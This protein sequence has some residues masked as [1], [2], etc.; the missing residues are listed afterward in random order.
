[1][2]KTFDPQ[3]FPARVGPPLFLA[4]ATLS[5]TGMSFVQQGIVVMSVFFAALYHLTLAQMGLVTTALSLGIMSSM[6]LMGTVVDRVGPRKVLFFGAVAMAWLAWAM[7]PVRGFWP[8]LVVLYALGAALAMAP[9]SGTKAVFTAFRNRPRGMVMGIR[10][11]GVPI[12]ALL[13]ASLLPR[14]AGGAGLRVIFWVFAAELLL[15]GWLFSAAMRPEDPRPASPRADSQRLG[16]P[17]IR[18]VWRPALVGILLVAGQYLLLAFSLSDLSRVHHVR[19]AA[20]G[21]IVAASQL[22]GGVSRVVTGAISDRLGGRR[23]PVIAW[24]GSLGAIMALLVAWLPPHIPYGLLA[25]IWF[26]FG[27]GAVGWNALTLTWAGE[28]VSPEH[29]GFAMMGVGTAIFFGSAVF[30]PLFGALVDATHRFSVG[31]SLLAVDLAVAALLAWRFGREQ[32][33][34]FPSRVS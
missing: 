18:R 8:L 21:L 12:G 11:T 33:R 19:I 27:M 14:I 1:M 4:L 34:P 13:A 3:G 2:T 20:A 16:W 29:S 10:Q 22:G 30:P 26:F 6:G 28:L 17:V 7:I 32:A 24:C 9:A 5:Q 23:T 31:F 25:L 15:T